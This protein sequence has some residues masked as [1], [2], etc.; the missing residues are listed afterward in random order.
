MNDVMCWHTNN[1]TIEGDDVR[2]NNPAEAELQA[3]THMRSIGYPDAEA[4]PGGADGGIDIRSAHAVG[5]V[6]MHFKP[7]GRPDLQRLFGARGHESSK[8]M[9]FYA[10]GGYSQAAIE[11]AAAVDMVLFKFDQNGTFSAMNPAAAALLSSK[12]T[13][14]VESRTGMGDLA[15]PSHP[16]TQQNPYQGDDWAKPTSANKAQQQRA[17]R[18]IAELKEEL[19]ALPID[20]ARKRVRDNLSGVLLHDMN[21]HLKLRVKRETQE[22]RDHLRRERFRTPARELRNV[23]IIFWISAPLT[24]LFIGLGLTLGVTDMYTVA[25][26]AAIFALPSLLIIRH[27][28]SQEA[29]ANQNHGKPPQ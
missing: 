16:P 27:M 15:G 21:Q 20:V 25:A 19:D 10:H 13:S 11:Y 18:A 6:K 1:G 28:K 5:Q 8:R 24:V 26:S 14:D 4:R 23:R 29:P 3:A 7:T 22:Y 2:I 9:V 12:R 17:D